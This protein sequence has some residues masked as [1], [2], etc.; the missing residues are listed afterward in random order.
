MKKL[1]LTIAIV[2]ALLRVNAQIQY[3]TIVFHP[4]DLS[5][6]HMSSMHLSFYETKAVVCDSCNS[7]SQPSCFYL[8]TIT[9]SNTYGV[10]GLAQPYHF[11]STV[12]VIGIAV[13]FIG[14]MDPSV[15]GSAFFRIMDEEFNDLGQTP[16]YPW[17]TPDS[18]GYKRHWFFNEI[19][20][21][22]F[23]LVSDILPYSQTGF[24]IAYFHAWNLYDSTGCYENWRRSRG[25]PWDTIFVGIDYHNPDPWATVTDT[26]FACYFDESPWLKKDD[27]WMR[28]SDDPVYNL[29]QKT[30]IEFLPILKV[31]REDTTNL[32]NE[33]SI[34]NTCKL[35]PNPADN[36]LNIESDNQIR[37]IEFIDGLGIKAKAITLNKKE[38]IIDISSLSK[39]NY[40]VNITT[41]K[42][43][44]TKKLVVQ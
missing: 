6:C 24:G 4:Y 39:G 33:I 27:K 15:Y 41:D 21:R 23:Y 29:F 40:I 35:F 37:V 34:D 28:F 16:I 12:T 7:Y 18:N 5:E 1:I 31:A 30:F 11:D 22:D 44:I 19:S 36:T 13:K 26:L 25:L 14:N 8:G 42:G 43:I 2:F 20:V 17:Y 38:V 3:D 9:G 10:Q 32:L